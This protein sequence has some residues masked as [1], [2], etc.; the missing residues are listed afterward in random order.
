MQRYDTGKRLR[1][2][3]RKTLYKKEKKFKEKE[4]ITGG[5]DKFVSEKYLIYIIT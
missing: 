5:I 2:K 1:I 3:K 4:K